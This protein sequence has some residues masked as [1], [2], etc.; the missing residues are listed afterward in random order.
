MPTPDD[1]LT[2][3]E[4]LVGLAED[5]DGSNN[6]PPITQWY[7]LQDAWC[8]MTVSYAAAHGGFSGDGGE[9]LQMPGVSTTT[10]K[11]WAYVPYLAED[12]TAA[13]RYDGSPQRGDFGVVAGQVHVFIVEDVDG[14]QVLTV[15]GNYGNHLVRNRRFISACDGFCHLPYDG[16]VSPQPLATASAIPPFPGFVRKGSNGSAVR[17]VQQR[18]FDRGWHLG[19]DGDFGA[20]TEQVVKQF[21]G[22]KGLEVD[23]VVGPITWTQLWLAPVTH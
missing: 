6:A 16:Q 1:V 18:L 3:L 21:Q 12:F 5:P 2:V 14:D 17:Q 7:G 20:Q 13:G 15:E 10:A 8:A 19:V 22:E 4:P 11:G 23:G 9:T